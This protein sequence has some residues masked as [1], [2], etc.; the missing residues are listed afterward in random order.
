M[1]SIKTSIKNS[2]TSALS[3][4][5]LLSILIVAA[6]KYTKSWAEQALGSGE[7]I[8]ITSWF[9]F[10]LVYNQGAAFGLFS[11]AGGWQT[12]F[13]AS[14]AVLVSFVLVWL[15]KQLKAHERL[16]G[17]AYACVLGGAIGNLIDRLMYGKVVDFV[18]WFYQD[19]HWPH[20]NIA[21]IAIC[22]GAALLI[23]DALGILPKPVDDEQRRPLE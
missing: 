1:P 22:A 21:D 8:S 3:R 20:F 15:I 7:I 5:L 10:S 19:Y 13:F 14:I 17:L 11:D 12:A 6:D 4:Y 9:D 23:V 2:W 16:L 18:H